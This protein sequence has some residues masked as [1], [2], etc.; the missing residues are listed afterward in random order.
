MILSIAIASGLSLGLYVTGLLIL[1]APLPIAFVYVRRGLS[2]ALVAAPLALVLLVVLYQ[3]PLVSSQFLPFTGLGPALEPR[4][5]TV[6]GFGYFFYYLWMG[7]VIGFT[8]SRTFGL[9]R[10]VAIMT[11][12]SF[13]IPLSLVLGL[14]VA[15]HYPLITE[16]R[17]GLEFLL[18]KMLELQENSGIRGEE[19]L[20]LKAHGGE[21]VSRVM[22]LLP[23]FLVNFTL[24][25]LSLNLLFLRR[26]F[27][28]EGTFPGWC[29][30]QL[31]RLSERWIWAPI[32]GGVA[33]FLNIYLFRNPVLGA[34]V[35][36]LLVILA[37]VYFYQGLAVVS[38]FFR[39]RF[40]PWVRLVAYL[41]VILF[42]QIVGIFIMALGLFDFWFD[43]RKLKKLA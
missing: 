38:F 5:M 15:A 22:T 33:F 25:T 18:A 23:A 39:R 26:W 3:T 35:I 40:S 2:P 8:A 21:V 14:T 9:E 10:S 11:L 32:A 30:F 6:L 37:A 16:I 17:E 24:I 31:W 4:E 1:F 19:I 7:L 20:Y 28:R 13:L 12:A 43:F 41:L 42:V 27:S 34:A 36:N 29:E